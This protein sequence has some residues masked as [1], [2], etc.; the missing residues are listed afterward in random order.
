MVV[1]DRVAVG[2]AGGPPLEDD[3]GPLGHSSA[4]RKDRFGRRLGRPARG[5]L[6]PLVG[7]PHPARARRLVGVGERVRADTHAGKRE[8]GHLQVVGDSQP[9]QACGSR[10]LTFQEVP[11]PRG[12]LGRKEPVEVAI[13]V[14]P[15]LAI[16]GELEPRAGPLDLQPS[17][18]EDVGAGHRPDDDAGL[19]LLRHELAVSLADRLDGGGAGA[20]GRLLEVRAVFPRPIADPVGEPGA[21]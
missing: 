5:P 12:P 7:D 1:G 8:R 16:P 6:D 9:P 21:T 10:Q 17:P 2:I 15:R 3:R 13:D 4:W 18:D 11:V 14:A 20:P 19:P